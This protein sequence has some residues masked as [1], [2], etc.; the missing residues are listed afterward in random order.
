MSD[1]LRRCNRC[2]GG[3]F[4]VQERKFWT[5]TRYVIMHVTLRHWCGSNA[6]LPK[7]H[8][9]IT[10]KTK[11]ECV[12][13]WNTRADDALIRRMGEALVEMVDKLDFHGIPL[14]DTINL[15]KALADLD[16][17]EKENGSN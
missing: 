7:T 5:G 12:S 16:A 14:G 9:E 10:A 15:R 8:T 3:E 4:D 1:K 2:G 17:W 11:E 6:G 13:I